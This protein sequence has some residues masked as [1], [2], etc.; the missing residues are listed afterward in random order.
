MLS[1]MFSCR[2]AEWR[3]DTRRTQQEICESLHLELAASKAPNKLPR[4]VTGS[5]ADI[6]SDT[7]EVFI[8]KSSQNPVIAELKARDLYKKPL[9]SG[10]HDVTC[11]WFQE[12]TDALDGGAAYFEPDESFPLGGFCCKHSHGEKYHIQQL[13]NYLNIEDISARHKPTIRIISGDLDKVVDAA[14]K[15]LTENGRFYQSGNLIVTVETDHATGIQSIVPLNAPSLMKELAGAATW[16]KFDGRTKKQVRC[17]PPMQH[18]NILYNS[19]RFKHL[20]SLAGLAR[21]PYYR[22]SNSELVSQPGYDSE[23]KILSA[24]DQKEFVL[25]EP[26]LEEATKALA[27][28]EDLIS[29][30][31]FASDLDKSATLSAIF[32]AVTR[33]TI[34][35]A[36]AFHVKAPTSGS[37]KTYLCELIGA[38]AGPAANA[39]VSYPATSEEATKIILSLLLSNPPVIEFDDLDNN[40]IP[41]GVIKR[42]LTSENI[43]D[44]IL[45]ISKTATVNTR[46]LFL[47]SGNNVGP[48]GDLLRRVLTINLDPRCATPATLSYKN[49]PV[50]KIRKYREKYVSAVLTIIQAWRNAGSPRADVPN[51][52]TYTGA[53]SEYCRQPLIWVGLPDP[54]M[55]LIDQITHDPDAELLKDLMAEW[56]HLFSSKPI[57]VRKVIEC[58]NNNSKNLL[59]VIRELPV[60]DR[61]EI[62]PS[63]LGWF[64]KKNANRI[65]GNYKFQESS[66]DGRKAWSLIFVSPNPAQRDK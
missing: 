13:L 10:K 43:T 16:M 66:A 9:G 62:N 14:E 33:P 27:L 17:D 53:W 3:P 61:K 25:P 58:A 51:I 42:M 40:L 50:E 2:L 52:A 45:G 46:T 11:P 37:G 60:M 7:D 15:V 1:K 38:F 26:T 48:V 41:H 36:P 35:Y 6:G 4:F 65:I 64:L 30:F 5:L 32:T 29:E 49:N 56:N 23:S 39:K 55:T 12:H 21:Q 54:G 19:S 8:P 47:S 24:F 57:T 59:D 31:R 63:K 28:L 34:P 18:I 20:P 44:R 22:E